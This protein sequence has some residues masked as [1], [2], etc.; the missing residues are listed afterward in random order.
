MLIMG[1]EA[2]MCEEGGT[3]EISVPSSHFTVNLK[4]L[5]RNKFFKTKKES[6]RT[7]E[8]KNEAYS[9]YWTSAF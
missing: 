5:Y 4:L 3:W 8:D 6:W 9:T 2:C 1:V 7:K